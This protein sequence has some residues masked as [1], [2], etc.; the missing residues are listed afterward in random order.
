MEYSTWEMLYFPEEMHNLYQNLVCNLLKS[1]SDQSVVSADSAPGGFLDGMTKVRFCVTPVNIYS[2]SAAL[3]GF[4]D[5]K[6]NRRIFDKQEGWV[7]LQAGSIFCSLWQPFF[8]MF[9]RWKGELWAICEF[10]LLS[11]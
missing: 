6:K 10:V 2:I 7:I 3:L 9:L 11:E 8:I 5:Q 4:V 1:E